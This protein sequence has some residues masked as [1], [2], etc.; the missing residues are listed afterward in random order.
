MDLV[1]GEQRGLGE[2]GVFGFWLFGMKI[3]SFL[4]EVTENKHSPL[5][6]VCAFDMT[7]CTYKLTRCHHPLP[8]ETPESRG[9]SQRRL[10]FGVQQLGQGWV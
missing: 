7:V 6:S 1:E 8:P 3:F 10:V 9:S 5:G 2:S 4:K